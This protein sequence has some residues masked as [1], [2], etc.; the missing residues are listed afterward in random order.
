MGSG[1]SKSESNAFWN[2]LV[3]FK[4]HII[5]KVYQIVYINS[6]GTEISQNHLSMLKWSLNKLWGQ[7]VW[8]PRFQ[9]PCRTHFFESWMQRSI[10]L[11]ENVSYLYLGVISENVWMP[12]SPS[13]N[14]QS[15]ILCCLKVNKRWPIFQIL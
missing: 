7:K 8:I 2:I 9:M 1:L 15:D 11:D 10:I 13:T 3:M 14:S 12:F 4:S 6:L 5:Q